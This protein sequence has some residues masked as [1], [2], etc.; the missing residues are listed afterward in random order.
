LPNAF[1]KWFHRNY[2]GKG[3][4]PNVTREEA[5]EACQE[6]EE[7][8][9]PPPDKK[10]RRRGGGNDDGGNDPDDWLDFLLPGPVIPTCVLDGSCWGTPQET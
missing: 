8:G 3:K 6:W 9:K 1:W 2:K 4:P 10:G 7:L 5:K